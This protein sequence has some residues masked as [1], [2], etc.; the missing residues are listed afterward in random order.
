LLR[1]INLKQSA[2]LPDLISN[3]DE[4]I[5]CLNG[6]CNY[7]LVIKPRFYMLL[8]YVNIIRGSTTKMQVYLNKA[9]KYAAS[10]GNKMILASIMQNKRV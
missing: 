8:A 2:D 4:M 6:V 5:K 1:R 9:Q 10:Q 3:I 7:A